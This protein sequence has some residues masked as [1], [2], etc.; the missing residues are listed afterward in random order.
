MT[1]IHA[2]D[3]HRDERWILYTWILQLTDLSL[4]LHAFSLCRDCDHRVCCEA[5]VNTRFSTELTEYFGVLPSDSVETSIGPTV[6]VEDACELRS[7]LI[8]PTSWNPG[9][10]IST[11][12]CK[13][14]RKLNL[15]R[16]WLWT[17]FTHTHL[18]CAGGPLGGTGTAGPRRMSGRRRY[19]RWRCTSGTNGSTSRG[20]PATA[21]SVAN[22]VSVRDD[23]RCQDQGEVDSSLLWRMWVRRM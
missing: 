15:S 3:E 10:S 4:R 14:F 8:I 2:C 6:D 22:Y 18:R 1:H 23:E 9:V 19:S 11:A 12:E 13:F 16:A 20:P 17:E 5:L 7:A 21:T